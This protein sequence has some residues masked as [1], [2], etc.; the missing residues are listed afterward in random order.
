[1]DKK[2]ITV[3]QNVLN[4]NYSNVEKETSLIT[5]SL[6]DFKEFQALYLKFENDKFQKLK[7]FL[8]HDKS[9]DLKLSKIFEISFKESKNNYSAVTNTLPLE[10]FVVQGGQSEKALQQLR[11]MYDIMDEDFTVIS[12][13]G[14]DNYEDKSPLANKLNSFSL[15]DIPIE[16]KESLID[17]LFAPI[18]A[19]EWSI[20]GASRIEAIKTLLPLY[21]S[22]KVIDIFKEVVK[23]SSKNKEISSHVESVINNITE[24]TVHPEKIFKIKEQQF[25]LDTL[26]NIISIYSINIKNEN[27]W[28]VEDFDYRRPAEE[29]GIP[30]TS[31]KTRVK[32]QENI[33]QFKENIG[34]YLIVKQ[35]KPKI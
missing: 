11:N 30:V 15:K 33:N 27:V 14:N 28:E 6:S 4:D 9:F 25:M 19:M 2:L 32:I 8:H 3:L 12:L 31:S 5:K 16:F 17:S 23:S 24:M 35:T 7:T 22:P 1:M 13:L 21:T 34:S 26:A 10:V 29:M 18:G 20:D